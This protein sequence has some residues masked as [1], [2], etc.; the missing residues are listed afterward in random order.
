MKKRL[1]TLI[2]IASLA[3][4]VIGLLFP[5]AAHSDHNGPTLPGIP[6]A[7][8][9]RVKAQGFV[10]Y[11]LEANAAAYP[12]FRVQA[13]DVALAG[14]RLVGIDA[15]ETTGQPD[16]WLTMPDDL[17]FINTCGSRAAACIVYQ[18][19][20]IIIYF[21]RALLY[22]DWRS[23]IAHEGI[24]YGHAMG[25]HEQYDDRNFRCRSLAELQLNGPGA[26]VMSC[27][28]PYLWE[29]QP[30]DIQTVQSVMFPQRFDGGALDGLTV[31]HGG[32]DQHT[33]RIAVF[34]RTYLGYLFF[35]GQYAVPVKGCTVIVCGGF[36]LTLPIGACTDAFIGHENALRGSWLRELQRVGGVPC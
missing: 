31:W 1:L 33:T 35:T 30:F 8:M 18:A 3:G 25:E 6:T 23:T 26:T 7:V 2:A 16:I 36:T 12:N 19:D 15:W 27:G 32:S 4:A 9:S 5:L 28:F 11:R 10:T 22:S 34:Y 29:A 24:N 20:P 21:R 14:V 17:T 13:Q